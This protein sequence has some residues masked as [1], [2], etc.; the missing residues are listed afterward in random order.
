MKYYI[1]GSRDMLGWYCPLTKHQPS[2]RI[3]S[4]LSLVSARREAEYA[5]A[6]HFFFFYI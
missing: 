5:A 3:N 1:K 6:S 4:C 2:D